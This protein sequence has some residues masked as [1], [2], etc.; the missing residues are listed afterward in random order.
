MKEMKIYD[1]SLKI[2]NKLPYYPGDPK[3]IIN[4]KLTFTEKGAN[5]LSLHLGTHSGTHVDAPL[6]QLDR[7][8]SL[9]DISLTKFAGEAVFIFIPKKDDQSIGISDLEKADIR[10]DD[11]V[12]I[13]T[14]WERNK[15]KNNYFN[16]FPYFKEEVADYL[17]LK[18]IKCIGADIPSLDRSDSGG[19]F[20]KKILS[21]GIVIIEALVN[22]RPLAGKRMFFSAFPLAIEKGDGSPVRAVAIEGLICDQ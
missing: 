17:I 12:I 15:Y 7:G 8:K 19:L 11:I 4:P 16:N 14:G 2:N 9:D 1:L 6:H 10:E 3:I 13:G 22:I 5:V 21:K 20:H 18:K